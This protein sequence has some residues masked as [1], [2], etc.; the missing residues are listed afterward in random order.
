MKKTIIHSWR[1]VSRLLSSLL[2]LIPDEKLQEFSQSFA[3]AN[4]QVRG[5]LKLF[6]DDKNGLSTLTFENY[7]TLLKQNV[8]YSTKN[9]WKIVQQSDQH[10]FKT[11][12]N[13]F[14]VAIYSKKL[15][16]II[17]DNAATPFCDVVKTLLKGEPIPNLSKIIEEFQ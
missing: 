17:I 1:L 11:D 9:V 8:K 12:K 14:F 10:Y 2:G 5:F 4:V 13:T 16:A 7:L 3:T 6:S 15:N